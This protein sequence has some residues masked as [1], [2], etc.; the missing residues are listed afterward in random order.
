ML[1]PVNWMKEYVD[2]D[3]TDRKIADEVTDTGSHVD[4]ITYLA[5]FLRRSEK[6][7]VGKILDLSYSEDLKKLTICKVDVGEETVQILTGAKN[8][9]KGDFVIVAKVG[10][11]LPDGKKIKKVE[12]D[13]YESFGMLCSYEELGFDD[14]IVPKKSKNGLAILGDG[15][16]AGEGIVKALDLDQNVIEFEITPNRADCLSI[17]GMAREVGAAFEKKLNLPEIEYE[18]KGGRIEN[19]LDSVEIKSDYCSSFIARVIR[20]VKIG[21]SPQWIQNKLMA[22]GM[23]PINNI[24]D[25]SNFVMLEFGQPL[26]TYDLSEVKGKKVIVRKAK[27]GE[28]LKT[29]DENERKLDSDMLMIADEKDSMCIAGIMGGYNSEVREN[30]KDILLEAAVFNGANIRNTSKKLKLRSEASIRNEKGTNPIFAELASKRFCYL[31]EKTKAGEI[32]EG[33]ITAGATNLKEKNLRLRLS[34]VNLLLGMDFTKEQVKKYLESLEFGVKEIEGEDSFDIFF[35]VN[36]PFFRT[37]INIEADLIEEIARMYKIQNIHPLPL[38]LDT[39]PGKK[40]GIR[41]FKDL[42]NDSLYALGLSEILTYS[43]IS[44]KEYDK[45]NLARDDSRRDAVEIINPLGEDFSVMRTCLIANMLEVVSKNLKN[46]I[47]DLR[48]FEIGNVFI[49]SGQKLPNEDL[50]MVC[51]LSGNYDFYYLKDLFEKVCDKLGIRGI[52]YDIDSE[53]PV[54]HSGRCARVHIGDENLG[55]LGE[56]HPVVLENF[57]IDKRVYAFEINLTS[58]YKFADREKK[59]NKIIKYPAVKRDLSLVV[60]DDISSRDIEET[61]YENGGDFLVDIEL[62]DIYKGKQI[63]EGKKSYT[64]KLEFV[65]AERTLKDEEIKSAFEKITKSLNDKYKVDLRG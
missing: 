29:L 33:E 59:Y 38:K 16:E 5:N 37:D 12:F 39:F 30:T 58:L 44:P 31:I 41:E 9:N 48:F 18:E 26:H 11:V 21:Q 1:V 62:F 50:S 35:D 20:N 10:A 32:C 8:M 43:F 7:V 27:E 61:M 25:I 6:I 46:R 57:E 55:K 56:I 65:S 14:S 23:R 15:V 34:R 47:E 54:F 2:I 19:Y 51:C 52:E 63:E 36:V 22:A 4:S 40:S 60:D 3:E 17:T 24:V 45:L 42:A 64:Y 13:G 53:D 49:K 28:I